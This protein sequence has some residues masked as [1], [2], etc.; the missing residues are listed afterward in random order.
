MSSQILATIRRLNQEDARVTATLELCTFLKKQQASFDNSAALDG[1]TE[2]YK[3]VD[4]VFRSASDSSPLLENG[5]LEQICCSDLSYSIR[6]LIRGLNTTS[7]ETQL[8]FSVALASILSEFNWIPLG[9]VVSISNQCTSSA[10][11]REKSLEI[12]ARLLC[13]LTISHSCCSPELLVAMA[14]EAAQLSQKEALFV[15]LISELLIKIGRQ[16]N[17][18]A[19]VS[20]DSTPFKDVAMLFVDGTKDLKISLAAETFLLAEAVKVPPVVSPLWLRLF[21]LEEKQSLADGEFCSFFGCC[22]ESEFFKEASLNSEE[23]QNFALQILNLAIQNFSFALCRPVFAKAILDVLVRVLKRSDRQ[24]AYQSALDTIKS[25]ES[26]STKDSKVAECLATIFFDSKSRPFLAVSLLSVLYNQIIRTLSDELLL[27]R[28]RALLRNE[29]FFVEDCDQLLAI[30]KVLSFRKVFT[31]SLTSSTLL[32]FS[33]R[34]K[35]DYP[36]AKDRLIAFLSAT[37]D[38]SV[39]GECLSQLGGS[40]LA[41]SDVASCYGKFILV[42]SLISFL[43]PDLAERCGKDIVEIRAVAAGDG[44]DE[45]PDAVFLDLLLSYLGEDSAFIRRCVEEVFRDA[46]RNSFFSTRSLEILFHPLLAQKD[47]D[48]K[49][50]STELEEDSTEPEPEPAVELEDDINLASGEEDDVN[51]DSGEEEIVNPEDFFT[52]S[53]A[54]AFAQK[55]IDSKEKKDQRRLRGLFRNKVVAL[56]EIFLENVTTESLL[57]EALPMLNSL[58]R[59]LSSHPTTESD[60]MLKRVISFSERL[61]Y[62]KSRQLDFGDSVVQRTSSLSTTMQQLVERPNPNASFLS[63]YPMREL[64]RCNATQPCVDACLLLFDRFLEKKHRPSLFLLI[65]LMQKFA[66]SIGGEILEG[67]LER[68]ALPDIYSKVP[69]FQKMLIVRLL[70]T[71]SVVKASCTEQLQLLLSELSKKS[72]NAKDLTAQL[73]QMQKKK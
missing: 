13:Y 29:E 42:L 11:K 57:L 32:Y 23:R 66:Q 50:P 6:R 46:T 55:R 37:F 52:T 39:L 3:N 41:S 65:E 31:G 44:S 49:D 48:L 54:T 68:K 4:H 59:K 10:I 62:K 28:L 73:L 70:R 72:E 15:T 9:L 67:V 12:C 60:A 47:A 17:F 18:L 36:A 25:L 64:L 16:V 30:V 8:G 35:R 24:L 34:L 2:A 53:I 5:D 43:F 63:A 61:A 56:I 33:D 20:F 40:S 71:I 27:A 69:H 14:K 1:L 21:E 19:N 51:L 7:K 58:V 45:Q 38:F 26:A 22:F